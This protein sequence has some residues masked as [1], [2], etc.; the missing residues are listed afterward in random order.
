MWLETVQMMQ[1]LWQWLCGPVWQWLGANSAHA[2]VGGVM[3]SWGW[4]SL[5][6][7]LLPR[8]TRDD[9]WASTRRQ[10]WYWMPAALLGARVLAP[11]ANVG[12]VLV[13]CGMLG[14]WLSQQ[15]PLLVAWYAQRQPDR[16][17]QPR[18]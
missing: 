3:L 6:G 5:L 15:R 13:G 14:L 8:L 10:A 18:R 9:D 1:T 7:C 11:T 4:G 12:D 2:V 17:A 16:R